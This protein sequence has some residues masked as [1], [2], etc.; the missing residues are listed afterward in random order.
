MHV[1]TLLFIYL[2]TSMSR[3]GKRIQIAASTFA[4]F[5]FLGSFSLQCTKAFSG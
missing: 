3:R 1:L 2:L 4:N 5:V